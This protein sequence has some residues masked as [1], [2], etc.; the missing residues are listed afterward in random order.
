METLH[1]LDLR[2]NNQK[3][4]CIALLVLN[5]SRKT[6]IQNNFV[7]RSKG[8]SIVFQNYHRSRKSFRRTSRSLA[9]SIFLTKLS[10]MSIPW[11]LLRKGTNRSNPDLFFLL[12]RLYEPWSHELTYNCNNDNN[13]NNIRFLSCPNPYQLIY[14]YNKSLRCKF[15][16]FFILQQIRMMMMMMMMILAFIFQFVSSLIVKKKFEFYLFTL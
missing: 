11:Q 4:I 16:P 15:F 10:R 13:K 5:F 14:T 6:S 8:R 3:I 1:A 12:L 2:K 9:G 7:Q